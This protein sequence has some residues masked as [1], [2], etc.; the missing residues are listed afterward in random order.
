VI[1]SRS[2]GKRNRTTV[3]AP[4]VG[5]FGGMGVGNI[6][7]D[8]SMEAL[9][10]YLRIDHPDAI[11]DAMC[12]G[13]EEVKE[14]Y[15]LPAIPIQWSQRY[16]SQVPGIAGIALKVLGRGIDAYRTASWVRRHDVVIVPGM[17][18]FETSLPLRPWGFPYAMFLLCASGKLFGTKVAL[19]SVGASVISQRL[20][21]R[22]FTTAA[23]L[24]FYRSYRD[25]FSYDA[26]RGQGVDTTADQV[27]P[28][29]VFSTPVPAFDAEDAQIVG[30][31][32]MDYH[33][34]NDDRKRAE[35]IYASYLEKLK[36]FVRWLVDSDRKVRLYVG[37]TN[38]SDGSVAQQILAD[39][40]SYRPD[41]DPSWVVAEPVSTFADLMRAMAP[42]TTVVAT[43]YHNV[44]CALKLSKPTISIGYAPK[45]VALLADVGMS[46][47]CQSVNSLDVGRLIEQFKD[48]ESHAPELRQTIAARNVV[49]RRL[50]ESQF[51]ELSAALFPV[52]EPAHTAAERKRV[53]RGAG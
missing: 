26:M 51:A 30:V 35:E 6:G 14:R 19:V 29:L 27:Y 18:V 15:G 2:S 44:I 1:M 28:D 41:L 53:G 4:S 7:N 12:G 34:T 39:V 22:L 25:A 17:G 36:Y 33:G 37:D 10:S 23:R 50:L 13:P 21:R 11:L 8:A 48:L 32:V 43:R 20:T 3:A 5:L 40:R 38:D 42:A 49:N 47:Y 45:N 52:A 31:G 9:L 16:G 24:A 46:E